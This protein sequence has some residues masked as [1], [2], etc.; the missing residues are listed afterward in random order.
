[1]SNL[2]WCGENALTHFSAEYKRCSNCQTLIWQG[3]FAGLAQVTDDA[4]D[5]YGW[6]Y[7]HEHQQDD[8]GLPPIEQ[9]VISDLPERI[10][11]WLRT[12][13][14]YKKPAGQLLEIGCG[15]GGFVAATRAAGWESRGLE[16][17]KRVA[18]FAAT[19]W[20]ID[21]DA[22]P[23]ASQA[24]EPERFNVIA[25]FDVLE[26]VP[27]P[28]ALLEICASLL[29]PTGLLLIQTPSVPANLSAAN[30]DEAEHPILQMLLPREHLYLF[31]K[32][33]L[34]N[35]LKQVGLVHIEE[36]PALF[37]YDLF[38]LASKSDIQSLSEPVSLQSSPAARLVQA[39]VTATATRD[40]AVEQRQQQ[41]ERLAFFDKE[42]ANLNKDLQQALAE[43][44]HQQ[45]PIAELNLQLQHS[46]AD[47][48][49]RGI[50]IETL[51]ALLQEAETDR[52]NRLKNNEELTALL[53]TSE[54]DRQARSAQIETLTEL[55]QQSETDREARAAQI[56]SLTALL[57]ESEADRAARLN[58]IHLLEEQLR[59]QQTENE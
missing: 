21:V 51:T 32:S 16:L 33:G 9:R 11:Y 48:M 44:K 8:L 50:Q 23:L 37:P 25:I 53:A 30:L 12:L 57:Q 58:V 22:G 38:F 20:D 59:E 54:Q 39:L 7:W 28:A 52:A 2:C 24:Y 29:T 18:N 47:R 17:S 5:Y 34:K 35:L 19:T 1:M 10:S 26:H 49:A 42:I 31:A 40:I 14:R 15:H 56:E 41:A 6:R 4:N 27:N 3:D 13:L 36:Q 55:L 43:I 45:A 46:E